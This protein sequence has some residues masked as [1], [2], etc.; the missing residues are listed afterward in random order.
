MLKAVTKS[1]GIIV[2]CL[3]SLASFAQSKFA[4]MDKS[5]M[6]VSYYPSNF[7]LQKVQK[8]SVE[9]LI[10]RVLYSR[11]QKNGRTV[12]GELVE[13]GQVWRFGANE[14]TEIEFFRDVKIAGKKV[15]KGRYSMYAIVN[16]DKWTIILN[17]ELDT[18]GAFKYDEKK[19]VLRTDVPAQKNSESLEAFSMSFEKVNGSFNLLAG[20][21][22]VMVRLPINY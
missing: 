5:P 7:A 17:T 22:D 10:A 14:A 21:D 9:P 15:K 8:P 12:F 19:D 4:A 16:Q 20:W 6:D 2:M 18:W 11:P 1:T 3:L 13:F